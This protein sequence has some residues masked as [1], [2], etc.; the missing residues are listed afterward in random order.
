VIRTRRGWQ[1]ALLGA[2]AAGLLLAGVEVFSRLVLGLGD[3]PLVVADPEVEYLFKPSS[4]YRRFGRTVRYNSW[5]MR[6]REFPARKTDPNEFRVV[7]LGDSVINGGALTDQDQL[8]TSILER[9][10]G[11]RLG[12]AVVVG[13]ASA[14]SWGPPNMAAYLRKF[15]TFDA[16]A[17]VIVLSS[18]DAFDLPSG[19]PIVGVHPDF[20]DHTP[21]SAT[22]EACSRYVP[23]YLPFLRHRRAAAGEWSEA[24]ALQAC[25][26]AIVEMAGRA[27]AAGAEPLLVQHLAPS[28]LGKPPSPGYLHI[29]ETARS[30]GLRTV[31]LG[32]AF[33]AAVQ[34]GRNPYRDEIHPNEVG[35]EVIAAVLEPILLAIA[36]QRSG[37]A[38][39]FGGG[40]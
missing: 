40:P 32:P 26:G 37:G 5:S 24:K 34:A 7:F 27:R 31:Q 33:A 25:L 9:R 8:A 1:V 23:R 18:H 22:W 17:M 36:E 2:A 10:L 28:E 39:R 3:P 30:I 15:G 14:G 11:Q 19:E 13:N 21:W 29:A 6:S 16:D 38:G 35:Q 20:P 4:V 12:R